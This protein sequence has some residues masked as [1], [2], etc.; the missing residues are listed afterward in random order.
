VLGHEPTG[1]VEQI[2]PEVTELR[3]GVRVVIPFK[4]QLESAAGEL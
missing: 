1:I 4:S 2:G 3:V